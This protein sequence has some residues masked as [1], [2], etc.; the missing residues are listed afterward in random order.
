MD[1]EFQTNLL[2]FISQVLNHEHSYCKHADFIHTTKIL[3]VY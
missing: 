2:S 1:E 3:I